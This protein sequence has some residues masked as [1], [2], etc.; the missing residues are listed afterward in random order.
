MKPIE[1]LASMIAHA[2]T[3]GADK[4]TMTVVLLVACKLVNELPGDNES[5][6]SWLEGVIK[7]LDK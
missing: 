3:L 7:Q 5:L 1:V 6:Q 4:Q 2:F